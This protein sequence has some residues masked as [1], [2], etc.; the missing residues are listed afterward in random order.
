MKNFYFIMAF[1]F[2]NCF[3]TIA[4]CKLNYQNYS[5]VFEENFD[6]I[7]NINQLTSNWQF[8]HD[9]PGWGWGDVT[10]NNSIKYGEYYDESQVSIQPGGILRLTAT[11][12]NEIH[13]VWSEWLQA[14]RY[15]KYKSGMIQLR[16]DQ[17]NTPFDVKNNKSGFLYG[18]FEIRVKLPPNLDCFPS[19]WLTR[20]GSRTEIDIFEYG[21]KNNTITNSVIDWSKNDPTQNCQ[22]FFVKNGGNNLSDD[23]HTITCVWN[24]T[25]VTFFFDGKETRTVNLIQ[26]L[27]YDD[28]PLSI[29]ANLAMRNWFNVSTNYMDIDYIRVYKSKTNYKASYKNSSEYIGHNISDVSNASGNVISVSSSPNSI[30]PNPNNSNEVFFRGSDDYIYL[31]TR[32]GSSWNFQK[33]IFN[34]GNPILA[35]GDIKYLPQYDLLLYVGTNNRINLFGRSNST[36]SGFYHWYLSDNW[37]CFWCNTSDLISNSSGSLQVSSNGDVFF[38]GIDNKVHRYYFN[39]TSWT[40]EILYSSYNLSQ[41]S[42]FVQNDLIIDPNN[43]NVFY[44]GYD[45]RLQIF[46]LN[47]LGIYTHDWIDNNWNSNTNEVNSKPS[48]MIWSQ[49][50]N[51]ILYVGIDNKLHLFNWNSGWHHQ[52]IPYNYNSPLLGYFGADFFNGSISWFNQDQTLCYVGNDGRMQSFVLDKITGNWIHYWIDDFWN[53]DFF[54]S[55]NSSQLGKFSSSIF[56]QNGTLYYCNKNG[57]LSYFKYEPCSN[58]NPICN[59]D[60][61]T[62]LLLKNNIK[63]NSY[64]NYDCILF[65]N[66]AKENIEIKLLNYSSEYKVEIVNSFGCILFNSI[67]KNDIPIS[68]KNYS[69]GIYFCIVSVDENKIFKKFAIE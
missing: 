56:D 18:M 29:I 47:S 64:T 57:N 51:G 25:E 37:N 26:Q 41:P 39:N 34:D 42:D 21:E 6:N 10:V 69:P 40:H 28:F 55:F 65:P 33:L 11:K 16:S 50:L 5:L 35:F 20:A 19:F 15:P 49:I 53:T 22:G 14:N 60:T 27:T 44:K 9:D 30:A 59:V 58:V 62:K 63:K 43:N 68:L 23:F 61:F 38:K 17:F 3:E 31:A 36:S 2:L 24:P 66:P 7:S 46:Y 13:P 8:V 45:N 4:Q 48:S 1:L 52:L 67:I 12:L 32:N 54:H